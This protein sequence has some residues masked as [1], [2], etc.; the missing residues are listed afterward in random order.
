MALGRLGANRIDD[1]AST[2]TTDVEL[3]QCQ[4]HYNQCRQELLRDNLWRFAT[5][6]A[7]IAASPTTPESEWTY[8]MP[9]PADFL[10]LVKIYEVDHVSRPIQSFSMEG[11]MLLADS[12]PLQL[13]Y[14]ADVTNTSA[15]DPLFTT[16]LVCLLALRMAPAI[17]MAKPALTQ[18]LRAE[19]LAAR[20]RARTVDGRERNTRGDDDR[21]TWADAM[22]RSHTHVRR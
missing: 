4:L 18:L 11:T 5:Q 16:T 19:Y 9:L 12:A 10:R 7:E 21:P 8:Q 1:F 6:R 13:V 22:K 20:S 2:S 15:F 3:I 17:S 14:I